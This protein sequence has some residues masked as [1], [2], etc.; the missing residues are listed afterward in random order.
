VGP[1][2][3]LIGVGAARC[4]TQEDISELRL[5]VAALAA[6]SAEDGEK[7]TYP[8]DA[9][10]SGAP[11]RVQNFMQLDTGLRPEFQPP[12]V[13]ERALALVEAALSLEG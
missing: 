11:G 4:R 3:K 2:R 9:A 1:P 7:L 12:E 6:V 8:V 13:R 10:R 5:L